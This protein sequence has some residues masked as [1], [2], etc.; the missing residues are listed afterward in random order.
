MY[1]LYKKYNLIKKLI[2]YLLVYNSFS[3]LKES[4]IS[5]S[6]KVGVIIANSSLMCGSMVGLAYSGVIKRG[7]EEKFVKKVYIYFKLVLIE[8]VTI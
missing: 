1:Y 5:L 8:W 3:V 6:E 2:R 4:I 7:P